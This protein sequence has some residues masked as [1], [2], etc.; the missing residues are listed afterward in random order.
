MKNK[1]KLKITVETKGK[2]MKLMEYNDSFTDWLLSDG[3]T[4]ANILSMLDNRE[5]IN[6]DEVKSISIEIKLA[7]EDND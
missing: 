2:T 1:I 3:D 7:K 4:Q 5:K 6:I